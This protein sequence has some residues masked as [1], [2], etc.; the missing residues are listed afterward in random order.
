MRPWRDPC[1]ELRG[2]H[3]M[4]AD[5]GDDH[6]V[7]S[8]QLAQLLDDVLRADLLAGRV[9]ERV[10]ALPLCDRRQPVFG[11]KA[12]TRLVSSGRMLRTSP[13]IGTSTATFLLI[14]AGSTSDVDDGRL[15]ANFSTFPVTRSSNRAPTAMSTS[16]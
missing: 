15:G 11:G 3:L 12:L 16:Q 5:V 9:P 2:P 14:A 7:P 8:G 10:F 4:L 1:E 13:T 6:G